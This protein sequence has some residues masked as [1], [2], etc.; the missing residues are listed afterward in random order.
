MNPQRIPAA[1]FVLVGGQSRRMGRD[2]AL[3]E[4]EGKPLLSHIAE[5]IAPYVAEVALLG[6][7]ARYS[8]FGLAVLEDEYPGRGPLGALYTGLR[9]SSRDWN[10]FF[11]CDL[12]FLTPGIVQSLLE[13]ASGTTAQ[14]IVP[15]AGEQ[16]QPLC[17]AYHRS[18][19]VA[20]EASIQRGEDRSLVRLLAALRVEV[21]APEPSENLAEWER[22]FSNVNTAEQWEQ[23]QR[24]AMTEAR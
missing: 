2:K 16:W 4:F 6:S 18:C 20:V 11:A 7:P 12:P 23:M 19:L 5:L 1:G 10:L 21:L 9:N 24:T 22:I 3:L 15:K 17:A 14:A 13:R 8:G